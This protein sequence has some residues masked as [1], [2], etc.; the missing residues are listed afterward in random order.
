MVQFQP[1]SS[2]FIKGQH[3]LARGSS[4]FVDMTNTAVAFYC[5]AWVWN[6]SVYIFH[7]FRRLIKIYLLL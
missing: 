2:P 1:L 7:I 5:L 6:D 3:I 4:Y